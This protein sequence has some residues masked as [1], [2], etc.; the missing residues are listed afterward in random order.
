MDI[1]KEVE[2]AAVYSAANKSLLEEASEDKIIKTYTR[3]D[4]DAHVE[5]AMQVCLIPASD[6]R[7][8][9]YVNGSLCALYGI[10]K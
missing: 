1:L 6:K 9:E 2:A 10:E 8:R 7:M 5:L 3:D 4:I